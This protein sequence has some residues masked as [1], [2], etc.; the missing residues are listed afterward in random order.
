[1]TQ[2]ELFG[3][4]R[5]MGPDADCQTPLLRRVFTASAAANAVLTICGLGFFEAYLN[6]QPVSGDLFVPPSTNYHDRPAP[7]TVNGHIFAEQMA[8]RILCPQYDVTA[9]LR[10]GKNVLAVRLGNGYYNY[11]HAD[12][13]GTAKLCFLLEVT[14]TD[15]S[16]SRIVS[17]EALRWHESEVVLSEFTRGEEHDYNRLPADWTDTDCDETGWRPVVENPVPPTNYGIMKNPADRRFRTLQPTLLRQ[18]GDVKTYDIGENLTGWPLLR[19]DGTEKA[20]LSLRVAEG[21][22]AENRLSEPSVQVLCNQHLILHTDGSDRVMSPRFTWLAGRYFEVTGP[23]EMIGFTEIHA[24]VPVT[25]AFVCS[26]PVLNWLYDAFLRTQLDNMHGGIPSDCPHIER[27]G[28]TGD[29]Q[30]IG[31]TA[32]QLL[33]AERFYRKWI[34]DIAD[35]QDRISGHVQYTA[36]YV[37]SGGGPGGWGCAIVEVPYT[38][39]KIYGD[40]SF[41]HQLYP[42][43]LHYFDYLVA[44]S[45]DG[46]VV[47]DEPGSWCLGD[48]CT[49]DPVQLPEP[50]IN[51]Y[52]YAKSLKRVLT[53]CP[54]ADRPA[55]EARLADKLATIDAHYFDDATGSYCGGVQGADAFAVDLG[56]GDAR[57]LDNLV[58]KYTALGEFDTGIFG[59]DVLTRVLFERGHGE[60]AL[61]LLT[62]RSGC[63]YA[64]WM[65]QGATTLW[66][67]WIGRRPNTEN[68]IDWA[69]ERSRNHPMFGAP[70]RMLHQYV[71]GI[72]QPEE[73]K[74]FETLLIAPA[75]LPT[76]SFARG[77]MATPCGRVS[78]DWS[79][80]DDNILFAV[81]LDAGMEATLCWN[82]VTYPLHGGVN[83]MILPF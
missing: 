4:G 18:D 47:S 71:L 49:V 34:D 55:L 36:P 60:L 77:S 63:G 68:I 42:Q 41:L 1:M 48:W 31:E 50:Y 51:T 21:I 26:D 83:R 54:E 59:T 27:R 75:K 52:F 74:G 2:Q 65:R 72:R 30:L 70:V 3:A 32:M 45:R 66:E 11:D 79:R 22:T 19:Q 73:S 5:W 78:V 35:C 23:G 15:G 33:D 81:E 56:L 38:F 62:G 67:Y 43:M 16:V 39:A 46:V 10:E 40:D 28:Y 58:K 76:L 17:D 64:N 7:M 61:A 20:T 9:L 44:H 8:T 12:A 25:S 80:L 13:F 37:N 53:F 57:T 6:G 14:G 29:G 82:G 24:D 69:G